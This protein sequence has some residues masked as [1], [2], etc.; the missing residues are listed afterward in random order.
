MFIKICRDRPR[1]DLFVLQSSCPPHRQPACRSSTPS[2]D[3]RSRRG[4]HWRAG[5]L[6]PSLSLLES[7]RPRSRRPDKGGRNEGISLQNIPFS[8]Y[9]HQATC[10]QAGMPMLPPPNDRSSLHHPPTLRESSSCEFFRQ[11][12]SRDE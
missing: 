1:V 9:P 3:S 8:A 11:I 5:V 6:A 10:R 7:E 12:R 2:S 4:R